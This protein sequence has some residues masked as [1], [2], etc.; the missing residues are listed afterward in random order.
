MAFTKTCSKDRTNGVHRKG[1]E[2]KSKNFSMKKTFIKDHP[3]DRVNGCTQ[4]KY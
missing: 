1:I 2:K 3:K 4:K